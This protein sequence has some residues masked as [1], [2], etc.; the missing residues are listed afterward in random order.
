MNFVVGYAEF[1]LK[2]SLHDE[3]LAHCEWHSHVNGMT[4]LGIW[5]N[6]IKWIICYS[7]W[8]GLH[9][10]LNSCTH[11]CDSPRACYDLILK[12]KLI[13]QLH[14]FIQIRWNF[15]KQSNIIYRFHHRGSKMRER[16]RE[17]D[18]HSIVY[19]SSMHHF[20]NFKQSPWGAI[21]MKN[22]W[23]GYS[24]LRITFYSLAWKYL[25]RLLKS[26]VTTNC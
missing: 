20:R 22:K 6:T 10:V 7:L 25:S 11:T 1:I 12:S 9:S 24:D 4:L 3:W 21:L 2:I 13:L 14:G 23:T 8:L 26:T 16:E 15:P 18:L 5:G 17:I 19:Q